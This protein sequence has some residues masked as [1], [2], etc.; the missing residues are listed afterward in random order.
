MNR[1]DVIENFI[2]SEMK[3]IDRKDLKDIHRIYK[4]NNFFI[5]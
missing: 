5:R 1:L 3:N 2:V 4:R